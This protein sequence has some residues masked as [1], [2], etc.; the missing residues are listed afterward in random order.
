[1]TDNRTCDPEPQTTFTEALAQAEE[2]RKG[3]LR[4]L[5][6]MNGVQ[7][8]AAMRR[9]ELTLEQ[10]AAWSARYPNEVPL[11]DGEFEWITVRTP[12]AC[13]PAGA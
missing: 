13:E 7:R 5:W 12:E 2:A 10:L 1:M 4:S 9:G 11:L 6:K 8:V 3:R